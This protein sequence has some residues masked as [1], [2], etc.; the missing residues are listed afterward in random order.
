VT[1]TGGIAREAAAGERAIEGLGGAIVAIATILALV[2]IAI[3]VFLNPAWIGLEQGRANAAGWTGWSRAQVTEVTNEV[4]HD[5][6]V[7]PPDFAMT[8]DGAPVF[9]AREQ[10]HMRDTRRV[11]GGFGFAVLAALV[12]LVVARLRSGGNVWFWR[13]VAAGAAV[14]GV[15]VVS[16]GIVFAVSFDTAFEVFHRLFFPAGSYDFDPATARLV[17]LFP[18][19]FWYETSI[20]FG[21]VIVVASAAVAWYALRRVRRG[22]RSDGAAAEPASVGS[23]QP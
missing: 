2:G 10:A 19:A 23:G 16:L 14:L 18:E 7:G 17:Q 8:V 9:D 6:I 5:L 1:A 20:A 15:A 11:F 3:L 12:V 21:I 22:A 13:S 4:L